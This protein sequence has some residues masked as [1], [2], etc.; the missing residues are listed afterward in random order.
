M[1]IFVPQNIWETEAQILYLK[2]LN[3]FIFIFTPT[4]LNLPLIKHGFDYIC[5]WR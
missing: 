4:H 3:V 1:H 5:S 2:Y